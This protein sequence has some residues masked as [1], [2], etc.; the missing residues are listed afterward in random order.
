ME[1]VAVALCMTEPRFTLQI[2]LLSSVFGV[3]FG[4]LFHENDHCSTVFGGWVKWR[5]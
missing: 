1:K 2:G 3:Q 4:R 5:S